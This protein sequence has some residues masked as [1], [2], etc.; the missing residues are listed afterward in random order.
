M[1]YKFVTLQ[2]VIK[3]GARCVVKVFMN[4]TETMHFIQMNKRS[5]NARMSFPVPWITFLT[6]LYGTTWEGT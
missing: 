2:S 3:I 5:K 6:N 4:I 1:V